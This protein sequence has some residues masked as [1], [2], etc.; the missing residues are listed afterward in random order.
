MTELKAFQASEL[1]AFASSN[2]LARGGVREFQLPGSS[3]VNMEWSCEFFRYNATTD[4]ILDSTVGSV[5]L[6][7]RWFWVTFWLMGGPRATR[8]GDGDIFQLL[9]ASY[10]SG[11]PDTVNDFHQSGLTINSNLTSGSHTWNGWFELDGDGEDVDSHIDTGTTLEFR[12]QMT[13][14]QGG[15]GN[16]DETMKGIYTHNPT[17][18]LRGEISGGVDYPDPDRQ[19]WMM[20]YMNGAPDYVVSFPNGSDDIHVVTRL[21]CVITV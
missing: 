7:D 1:K 18:V 19:L 4:T 11:T 21:K 3:D 16:A 12:S 5:L 2:L 14:R 8:R 10:T 15:Q 17:S 13:T 6:H 9:V 20:V